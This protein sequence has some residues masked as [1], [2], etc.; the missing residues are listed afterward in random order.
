MMV[1]VVSFWISRG[2]RPFMCSRN[3]SERADSKRGS[4][5]S[6]SMSNAVDSFVLLS[7]MMYSCMRSRTS[8][9]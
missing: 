5:E 4:C 6:L 7:G 2:K 8:C 1:R 9:F 3:V